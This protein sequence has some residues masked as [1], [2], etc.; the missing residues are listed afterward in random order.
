MAGKRSLNIIILAALAVLTLGW[1]ASAAGGTPGD[2]GMLSLRLGVGAREAGMG[3]TGVASSR[4]ASALFWNPANNVFADF[5]TELVLQH[6]R[7]L[8][9]FNQQAAAVAHRA[10]QGVIGFMF[11]GLYSDEIERRGEEPVGV[12]EGTFRPYDLSLAAS[13]ARGIGESF[14]ASVTAKF[15][16]ERID[17]YSDTGFAF[18]FFVTHQAVIDGLKFALG[19]TNVGGKMN[20]K[21]EPFKLPTT[22]RGGVAW[23]PTGDTFKERLTLTGDVVAPNDTNEKAHL[24][25]EFKLVPEFALRLGTRVNYENQGLTA[26]AGFRAGLLGVDY[27]YGESKVDGFDDGHKFSLNLIW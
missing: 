1:A 2:A 5:E 27:A 16:Y 13:Y 19:V 15:L 11:S 26:G 18:D 9:L 12:P 17:L 8:G 14:S 3:E 4:G 6:Y 22:I 7:Y 24:G 10:G 25:A 21:D 23:T 20:L